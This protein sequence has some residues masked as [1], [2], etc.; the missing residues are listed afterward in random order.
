MGFWSRLF[1]FEK[2]VV[3]KRGPAPVY[4]STGLR[5][6]GLRCPSS[7]V[8]TLVDAMII[9]DVLTQPVYSEPPCNDTV[10]E[11]EPEPETQTPVYH[12]QPVETYHAPEPVHYSAPAYESHSHDSHS[13]DSGSSDSGGG[14]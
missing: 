5:P 2:K 9:A 10:I 4:S 1:G 6:N 3:A 7:Y 11:P 13:Y 8:D 12:L 14:D